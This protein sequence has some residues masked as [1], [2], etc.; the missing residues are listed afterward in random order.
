MCR[1]EIGLKFYHAISMRHWQ[2]QWH[3]NGIKLTATARD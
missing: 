1:R 2:G 3:T